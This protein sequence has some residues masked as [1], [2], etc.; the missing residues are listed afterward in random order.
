MATGELTNEMLNKQG[1][2]VDSVAQWWHRN[3]KHV[4]AV[5][6]IHSK[7]TF[8]CHALEILVGRRQYAHVNASGLR[9]SERRKRTFLDRT[10][11]LRLQL[12]GQFANLVE[13][14]C[15]TIRSLKLPDSL[16]HRAGKRASL[17][18]E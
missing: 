2:I 10:Q 4:Q 18:S 7:S 6:Q 8:R 14:E 1:N 12:N 13:K 3:R 16:C 11:E 5:V 17:V 15:S 9:A